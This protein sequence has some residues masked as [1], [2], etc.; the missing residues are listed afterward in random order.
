MC[1]CVVY[2]GSYMAVWRWLPCR[3]RGCSCPEVC[4]EKRTRGRINR[5][6]KRSV[7]RPGDRRSKLLNKQNR[8]VSL[9]LNYTE[10]GLVYCKLHKTW[11]LHKTSIIERKK[12]RE[13]IFIKKR[14]ISQTR[15][16][17]LWF[18]DTKLKHLKSCKSYNKISGEQH[19]AHVLL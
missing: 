13:H 12:I 11:T 6:V 14:Q 17:L 19:L 15:S 4:H 2:G 9:S 8:L 1:W 10:A 18:S 3:I 5:V 16:A 7:K